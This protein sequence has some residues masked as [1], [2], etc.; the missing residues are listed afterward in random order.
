[1]QNLDFLVVHDIFMCETAKYAD[2]VLPAASFA[3]KDGTFTNTE[4]R[5][6]RVR[7]AVT[8]RGDSKPDWLILV[9]VAQRMGYDWGFDQP[10][11]GLGRDGRAVADLRGDQ[12]RAHRRRSACSGRARRRTIRARRSCTRASSRAGLG[13]F[14]AARPPPAGR[15]ARRASTRSTLITGRTLYH[16]NVGTM[17]RRSRASAERQPECFVEMSPEDAERLGVAHEEMVRVTSRR[18]ELHV[19]GLGHR[20]RQARQASGCPSTSA[21]SRPT[22]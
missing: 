18:G 14:F 12:L 4:R 2:V 15:T 9:E 16:Y 6:Q 13:K 10:V 11:G 3:E 7:Q 20:S 17:T 21:S 22:P 1:M 5:V 19:T 8:P